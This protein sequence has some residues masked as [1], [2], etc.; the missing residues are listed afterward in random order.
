MV[1]TMLIALPS[2]MGNLG[3][4]RI[5]AARELITNVETALNTYNV[6][7]NK[8][9]DSLEELT[10]E[11]DDEDALLQGDYIDPW[12]TEI[13]YDKPKKGGKRP[14][15][16]SAGEDKEFGTPD[17]ITNKDNGHQQGQ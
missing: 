11:T 1:M 3:K 7:Y 15:L 16:T 10:K 2:L 17:D 13:K 4:S 14:L 6:R 8:F 12:G 5:T 9:P